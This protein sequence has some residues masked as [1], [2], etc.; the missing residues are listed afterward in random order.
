[1]GAPYEEGAPKEV[2]SY[3]VYSAKPGEGIPTVQ[4]QNPK[5]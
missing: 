2:L 1:M 4:T 5:P 3:L